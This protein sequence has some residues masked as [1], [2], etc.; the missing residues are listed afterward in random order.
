MISIALLFAAF[1]IAASENCSLDLHLGVRISG[2]DIAKVESPSPADCCT[3]CST[4]AGCKAFCWVNKSGEAPFC[5]LKTK[6][7]PPIHDGNCVTGMHGDF[8]PPPPPSPPSPPPTPVPAGCRKNE[9]CNMAGRCSN[10]ACK[11]EVG[12]IGD[13]CERINFGHAYKCGEGGLCVSNSTAAGASGY[14]S[15]FTATW[16]GEVVQGDNDT[17]W[18]SR[19]DRYDFCLA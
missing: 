11:C 14:K 4:H 2:N 17:D 10:G 12:W 6:A 16:G 19:P 9:D 7:S 15:S 8:P 3:S 18:V 13:H 5:W 1:A